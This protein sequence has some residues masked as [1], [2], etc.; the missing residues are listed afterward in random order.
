MNKIVEAFTYDDVLIM[1]D[2]SDMLPIDVSTKTLFSRHI[3]LNVP[4]SSAPMDTVTEHELAIRIAQLGGIGVMH[5]HMSIQQQC[6]AV[7]KVK[8][9]MS[10]VIADPYT[11]A[12]DHK[13]SDAQTMMHEKKISG[14]PIVNANGRLVGIITRRD[15]ISENDN[16]TPLAEIMTKNLVTAPFGTTPDQ[17]KQILR[18][19]HVEKLLLIDDTFTLRGMITRKDIEKKN[20]FPHATLDVRGQL[21][22]A[23]AIGA[24]GDYFERA[25]EL[26]LCDTDALVIDASHGHSRNV[27]HALGKLKQLGVDIVVGNIATT[28]AAHMLEE[29]GADA[30][31]VGIGPAS[32][33][34]TRIISGC[35]VPQISAIMW[36]ADVVQGR[37]PIIADGG[38]RYPGDISKA[39]AAG[40]SSVMIGSLF[41]GTDESPGHVVTVD[42]QTYKIYRGMGSRSALQEGG[43]RYG[44]KVVPEGIE[45]RV[46]RRGPL[47]LVLNKLAGGLRQGMGYA[48]CANIKEMQNKTTFVR[49][50][51]AGLLESHPHGVLVTNEVF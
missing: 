5:R 29:E 1:P 40:A 39:I 14:I 31:R 25:Q 48:G 45:A 32:I 2:F 38:I 24:T 28:H 9:D 37:I 36:A 12:P 18:R 10:M 8:R 20:D 46:P 42:G 19:A 15:L 44:S 33:C 50:T 3:E 13:I 34:T 16:D 21:R 22:V 27:V 41:A 49:S 51:Y 26:V 4:I 35:G 23:A 17:A 47:E 43:D 11:L 7:R 30:L 6:A